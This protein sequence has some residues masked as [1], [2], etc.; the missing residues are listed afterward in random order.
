M[1]TID[2]YNIVLEALGQRPI[3]GT[4]VD[5]ADASVAQIARFV[6]NSKANILNNNGYGFRF[7]VY[8]AT[9]AVDNATNT[10]PVNALAVRFKQ[11]R[12][13]VRTNNNVPCVFDTSTNSFASVPVEAVVVLD[14]N[15]ADLPN[16]A[17]NAIAYSACVAAL[18]SIKG[19]V[20]EIEYYRKMYRQHLAALEAVHSASDVGDGTGYNSLSAR[21]YQV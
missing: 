16:E 12:Y 19:A 5:V 11:S 6:N 9:L 17:M 21:F 7:N 18:V 3:N 20:P 13:V 4:S 14:L 1:T 2:V 8:S 15:F 10:V